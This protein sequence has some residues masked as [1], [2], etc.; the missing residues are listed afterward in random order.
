MARIDRFS[1]IFVM[2][3][4]QTNLQMQISPEFVLG[5]AI[6]LVTAFLWAA[7][8]NVYKSQGSEATPLAI[9]ALKM[10][11]SLAVMAALVVLPFRTTA[12]SV[13]YQSVLFLASSVT[14]GLVIGDLA[15]LTAQDRIGV[16]YAYPIAATFPIATY[17]IS[18]YV[19]NEEI[20]VTRVL[21]ILLAVVGVMLISQEHRNRQIDEGLK[22]LDRLGL[23]LAIFSS[24]CWA[25]GTVLLQ[26]GVADVDPIDANFVRMVFGSGLMVPIFLGAVQRGMP[27][28]SKR[29]TKI[30]LIG[31]FFGMALGTLLYT[32]A[33]KLI[34]ATV[35]AVLGSVSP[36]FALPMSIFF[37]KE[38]FSHKSILGAILTVT[39]V[40]FVVLLA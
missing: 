27:K 20:L 11:L 3:N 35:A 31:A 39:G 6:A 5:S 13:P 26:L 37:L 15:F 14:I 33:V 18:I 2:R 16:S 23:A 32:Y 40:I 19:V 36:L 8:V 10:W 12:F 9:N 38:K 22:S 30:V 29:A 28:P 21:G 17:L 25:G 7:G 34:G 24:I 1:Y 4:S